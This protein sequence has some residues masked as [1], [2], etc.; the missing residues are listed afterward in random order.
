MAS[1]D[2]SSNPISTKEY[3]WPGSK[4]LIVE[5]DPISSR[6]FHILLNNKGGDL[7]HA[8]NGK[9]A[10]RFCKEDPEITMVLMDIQLPIM[11]GYD[12]T[13]RIKKFRPNLPIIAQ[14]AFAMEEDEQKCLNSGFD[15]YLSK[16]VNATDLY[17]MISRLL[18]QN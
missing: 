2:S 3:S 4:I 17:E 14:T 15:G 9:D 7:V 13:A 11:D 16:P 1:K 6:Y 5:D 8:D 10:V 18:T 12:A